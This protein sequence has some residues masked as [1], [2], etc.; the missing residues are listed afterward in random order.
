M[1]LQ[2][3]SRW[4]SKPDRPVATATKEA[5]QKPI[6]A[7]PK[8]P[9]SLFKEYHSELEQAFFQLAMEVPHD[10]SLAFSEPSPERVRALVRH[11]QQGN[12][13]LENLPRRPASLPMLIKVLKDD[14]MDFSDIADIL[15]SDPALTSRI[16]NTA[17]SPFFRISSESVDSIE[18]AIILLGTGG[19][20]RVISATVM[21]PVFRNRSKEISV[22]S[23]HVWAWAL[24]SGS[25][26]DHYGQAR[27]MAPG[28]LYLPGL[29]PAL[30]LLLI[31]RGIE[32]YESELDEGAEIDL[33]TRIAV[34]RQ[35]RWT[36]C[37]QI[38]AHWGL[39]EEYDAFL[40][41]AEHAGEPGYDSALHDALT[42]AT[43]AYLKARKASPLNE[44][45]VF[46]LISA[47]AHVNRKLLENLVLIGEDE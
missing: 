4:F 29:L 23:E 19:I 17:N 1:A 16:L 22:F 12:L 27:G 42:L 40:E 13:Q 37:R 7:R 38:R 21:N 41:S 44:Q 35:M 6:I 9:P 2:W 25:A 39:S 46:T 20:R 5:R 11:L 45:Q 3:F 31:H 26:S 36:L 15:L 34:I 24:M 10:P 18:Q 32:E 33:W 47:E 8:T 28:S 43:F 30:S 14:D